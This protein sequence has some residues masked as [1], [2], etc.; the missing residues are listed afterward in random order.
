MYTCTETAPAGIL[1]VKDLGEQLHHVVQSPAPR[2]Q[3]QKQG[4]QPG[5]LRART[6]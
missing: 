6:L 3:I 1:I 2:V 5:V 4:E